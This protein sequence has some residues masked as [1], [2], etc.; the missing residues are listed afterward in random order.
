ME[1]IYLGSN[2]RGP[3]SIEWTAKRQKCLC[4]GSTTPKKVGKATSFNLWLIFVNRTKIERRHVFF[5]VFNG[6][7]FSSIRHANAF[8]RA[9]PIF[10]LPILSSKQ[11]AHSLH[12]GGGLSAFLYNLLFNLSCRQK[13]A[14]NAKNVF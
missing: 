5:I 10:N 9:N 14:K 2:K 13:Y 1:E 12:F 8:G 3:N 4:F 6:N 7:F 11:N